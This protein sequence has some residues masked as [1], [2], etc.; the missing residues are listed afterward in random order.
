LIKCVV[1]HGRFKLFLLYS[2]VGHVTA[3]WVGTHQISS[4]FHCFTV[5]YVHYPSYRRFILFVLCIKIN[6]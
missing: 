5:E 2:F 1:V 4:G 6:K 3:E